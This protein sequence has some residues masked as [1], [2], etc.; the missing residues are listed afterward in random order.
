[1]SASGAARANG[2]A[3]GRARERGRRASRRRASAMRRALGLLGC[4]LL[5]A[6]ATGG[7]PARAEPLW[8]T[9]HRDAQRSGDDPD[10][11]QPV[12]PVLAWQSTDLGAPIW[13]Q[14]L[15]V[16]NRVY[17]ATVGDEAFALD[18]TTGSVVWQRSLGTPVPASALPCGDVEPTVGVVGT[19]VIDLGTGTFYAVADRWNAITGEAKHVLVGLS[20]QSG[21]EVLATDVDPPG[22]DPKA[23]LQRAALNLDEGRVVF[24]YG[25][26]DGDCGAYRGAVVAAPES[27]ATP[28]FWQYAP[29][30]PSSSGGAVWATGGPAVDRSGEVYAATGNPNPQAGERASTYDYSDSVVKLDPAAD[31]VADPQSEPSP[32]PAGFQPPTWE[33]ESNSDLDLGS[34]A[35]ELLPGG[36]LF[37]AGKSATGY[38]IDEATM[39]SVYSAP[40]CD[41]NEGFGGSFGGDAFA[42]G[43]IY[44]PCENGTQA[45]AYDPQ[46][47]T[48]TPLWQS[49]AQDA[50]GPP[51]VSGGLV[52]TIATGRFK[53]GGRTL[54]GLDPTTGKP[55]YTITMPTPVIDHFAS[56]S[57]AG[58][59]L[60]VASGSCI[61]AYRIA[62][63]PAG[64]AGP[65]QAGCALP[66]E[67]P[68]SPAGGPGAGA[69]AQSPAPGAGAPVAQNGLVVRL[70]GAHLHVSRRGLSRVGLRC[71]AP[72]RGTIE[73]QARLGHTP[74]G[75]PVLIGLG[76]AR[77]GPARGDF[78][79]ALRLRRR[80]M[81]HLRR[82]G[83]RLSLVVRIA[84]ASAPTQRVGAVLTLAGARQP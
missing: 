22:A 32:P 82:H 20:L 47:Q 30:P 53:G 56:P 14:P 4:G 63:L 34:A 18:A 80:A 15:V 42:G 8:T 41:T 68:G 76:A 40:V 33:A 71:S 37:Q 39:K 72:C 10:A 9:Y 75:R 59:R 6:L 38:L 45:L 19:P 74:H 52:W 16:G 64:E 73:L 13:S 70:R 51:I 26:N 67:P 78:D 58:G 27:G 49:E 66:G 44:M 61:T 35:P 23:L 2:A 55:R 17:V 12:A 1:V 60:F 28:S 83:G 81:A 24:G 62:Q 77:F 11:T 31:F 3:R 21:E 50:V 25:G 5:A 54:Y 79:V 46:A 7:R 65:G 69:G 29:A 84:V 48:F 43:T 36:L 57:A